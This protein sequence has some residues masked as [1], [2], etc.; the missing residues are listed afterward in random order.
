MPDN[1]GILVH[2]GDLTFNGSLSAMADFNKW[3]GELRDAGKITS[4]I[5]I[6]GNHD[7]SLYTPPK[8]ARGLLSN[9]I[10][11]E[12]EP[13]QIDGVKFYGSPWT[14]RFYDW[15][16]MKD[17]HEMAAVWAR[18]PDDTEVLITH[19]PPHMIL[20]YVDRG[21]NTGCPALAERI[22]SL[23]KLR[24][25]IFGHIHDQHGFKVQGDVAYVNASVLDDDYSDA[26]PP[27]EV[28][29]LSNG[30]YAAF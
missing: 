30:F 22:K 15:A 2:S 5:V 16:F 14:Q 7:W 1:G 21:E 13:I 27:I 10:Y 3:V 26:H 19:G 24:L 12:D 8:V 4:A 18:I 11:L 9:C 6:A 23:A 20:D 17:P 28:G 29:K 25:H